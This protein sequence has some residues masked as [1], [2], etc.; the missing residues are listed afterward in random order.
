MA[1]HSPPK[2]I[3]R[4]TTRDDPGGDAHPSISQRIRAHAP[5]RFERRGAIGRERRRWRALCDRDLH[6]AEGELV[7]RLEELDTMGGYLRLLIIAAVGTDVTG[8]PCTDPALLDAARALWGEHLPFEEPRLAPL[9]VSGTY[10]VARMAHGEALRLLLE[11]GTDRPERAIR[12]AGEALYAEVDR[13]FAELDARV[14]RGRLPDDVPVEYIEMAIAD[15]GAE[16]C[17]RISLSS[18]IRLRTTLSEN[19]TTLEDELPGAL[20]E[21]VH[22]FPDMSDLDTFRNHVAKLIAGPERRAER[23]R[24]DDRPVDNLPMADD[25]AAREL[26]EIE[27][28]DLLDR[29][30][31]TDREREVLLLDVQGFRSKEI[32]EMLGTTEGT[33]NV[34]L[35]RARKKHRQTA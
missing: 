28:R 31:L 16:I 19:Q 8:E 21:A 27:Y 11:H 26:V 18:N 12:L 23:V 32:A 10:W 30:N 14:L 3:H 33:V 13:G 20:A 34:T 24:R 15:L 25:F 1:D 29:A 22:T 2:Q 5:R 9:I 6:A 4:R 7:G 17:A 35:H